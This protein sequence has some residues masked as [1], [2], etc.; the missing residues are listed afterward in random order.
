[1]RCNNNNNKKHTTGR[2]HQQKN[3][4]IGRE[5]KKGL[6]CGVDTTLSS[7]PSR[8]TI[9]RENKYIHKKKQGDECDRAWQITTKTWQ[10]FPR[11]L[12]VPL[13]FIY[14]AYKKNP[15]PLPIDNS[16]N[17]VSIITW[18]LLS[19]PQWQ[20]SP[21]LP[22]GWYITITESRCLLRIHYDIYIDKKR[23]EP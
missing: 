9:A 19:P 13:F 11:Y 12:A 18:D 23:E 6:G 15:T 16:N 20:S 4:G 1:M 21:Q 3:K 5:E 2:P 7:L 22:P 10:Y 14:Q 8:N 17:R